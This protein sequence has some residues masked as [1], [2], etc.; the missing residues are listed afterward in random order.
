MGGVKSLGVLG[1]ANDWVTG[2][3]DTD[4]YVYWDIDVVREGSYEVTL[5]YTCPKRELGSKMCVQIASEQ[6]EGIVEKAH[7]PEPI[8]S[9]DRV[10]RN[11]VYEKIWAPLTLGTVRLK[12]GQTRLYVKALNIPANS[13]LDLKAVRIRQLD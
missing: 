2:W 7:D 13:A 11:E 5:M 1:Y 8:P 12:K 4:M 9:P 3:T 10:P 6:L